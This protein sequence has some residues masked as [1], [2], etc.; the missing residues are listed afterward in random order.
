VKQEEI[1]NDDFLNADN[2]FKAT[3]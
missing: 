3:T 1:L 2:Q